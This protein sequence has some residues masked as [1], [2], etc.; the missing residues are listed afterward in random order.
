MSNR[1]Y[2]TFNRRANSAIPG[3]DNL[4]YED[5]GHPASQAQPSVDAYGIDSEFGEAVTDGPYSSG[6]APASYGW[7]PDHP[8]TQEQ[9]ISDYEETRSLKEQNL[10]LAMERKAA[11]CIEIAEHRLGKYASQG[12]V[13]DLAL[14]FMDLPNRAINARLQRIASDF[15]AGD[16][17]QEE[18]GYAGDD[19]GPGNVQAE[20][21]M[22]MM[23]MAEDM[24]AEDLMADEDLMAEDLMADEDLMAEEE[25]SMAMSP[26]EV[27]AEEIAMLRQANQHLRSELKKKAEDEVQEETGYEGDDESVEV[28]DDSEPDGVPT[29][30]L[31]GLSRLAS[32]LGEMIGEEHDSESHEL[33][34]DLLAEMELLAKTY[35]K[36]NDYGDAIDDDNFYQK[37]EERGARRSQKGGG[38][39]DKQVK[40]N[41]NDLYFRDNPQIWGVK[42][43]APG[44]KPRDT[45][46]NVNRTIGEGGAKSVSTAQ[47]ETKKVRK[48]RTR[49][50]ENIL[51]EEQF[52][53]LMATL[54]MVARGNNKG[55][56]DDWNKDKGYAKTLGKA[57]TYMEPEE[58]VDNQRTKGKSGWPLAVKEEYN[59]E[60]YLQ[61]K[62]HWK[63]QAMNLSAEEQEMLT[64]MLA[65]MQAGT[66]HKDH[67][68]KDTPSSISG[69][70]WGEGDHD[71]KDYHAAYQSMWRDKRQ[72]EDVEASDEEILADML[73][74][75][76]S[77]EEEAEE[78]QAVDPILSEEE[79]A[80]L[81]A[82]E[83]VASEDMAMMYASEPMSMEEVSMEEPV[84]SEE[85]A[86]QNDPHHFA[87]DMM[88]LSD[89]VAGLDPKLARIFSAGDEMQEATGH[90]GED[91]GPGNASE[92]G[93]ESPS[94]K[95]A[96]FRPQTTARQSSVKTLGNISRE[97]S[98]ASDE[99]SKLW[100]SAPD[101]S[102]FF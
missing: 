1:R 92:N 14:R 98:S 66:K 87:E 97:A 40:Q 52:A 81:Q 11:K 62:E 55:T 30:K 3:Y 31:A 32:V 9:T 2:P 5:F 84:A 58:R 96:S 70:T 56:R 71:D 19:V 77:S 45:K 61:N 8:A 35:K 12:E 74:E 73:A 21:H 60:Y 95:S 64:E 17:M 22:A 93:G 65:E 18:T 83:P 15:L 53:N 94:A 36:H 27:L 16:E 48:T 68:T 10:K 34:A 86:G 20:S 54:E 38:M 100:E 13:E 78:A 49:E 63:K 41:H 69:D 91:V 26:A 79:E 46:K 75:I 7:M 33:M 88:G 101:V 90:E 76:E 29:K 4:G 50:A 102:K 72:A 28:L 37:P 39:W 89:E 67:A 43:R 99:L 57:F 85:E 42:S 80:E 6:P 23:N 47:N 25:L 51:S 44:E 59:G 82:E 24:M